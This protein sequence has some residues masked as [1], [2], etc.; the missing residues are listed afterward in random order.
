MFQPVNRNTYNCLLQFP[1]RLNSRAVPNI[2]VVVRFENYILCIM[3]ICS[4]KCLWIYVAPY[5]PSLTCLVSLFYLLLALCFCSAD[6]TEFL[7]DWLLQAL[8][9][10]FRSI[11][12]FQ[13]FA[14]RI[15]LLRAAQTLIS[16]RVVVSLSPQLLNPEA[17][18]SLRTVQLCVLDF[19]H[20]KQCQ[21][22]KK[23]NHKPGSAFEE[24]IQMIHNCRR[25]ITELLPELFIENLG[26]HGLHYNVLCAQI[27]K[28]KMLS[29]L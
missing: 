17:W 7:P 15:G 19:R 14:K 2:T 21:H 18:N 5:F 24:F 13:H 8:R 16:E 20:M 6:K 25:Y 27:F 4:V 9:F 3:H 28:A 26:R 10:V 29:V 12:L 11:Q 1:N 22:R 23:Y